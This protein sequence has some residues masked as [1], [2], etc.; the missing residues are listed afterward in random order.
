LCETADC[1]GNKR[2]TDFVLE[3][4]GGKNALFSFWI[5]ALEPDVVPFAFSLRSGK[6]ELEMQRK[7]SP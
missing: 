2:N 7:I 1:D 5:E 4:T 6:D 3:H